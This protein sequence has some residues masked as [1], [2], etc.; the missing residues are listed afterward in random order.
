[1][2][3]MALHFEEH[4]KWKYNSFSQVILYDFGVKFWIGWLLSY[5]IFINYFYLYVYVC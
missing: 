4:P 3:P 5:L 1:M 2:S